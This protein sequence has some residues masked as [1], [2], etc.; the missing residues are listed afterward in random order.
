MNFTENEARAALASLQN[1]LGEKAPEGAVP[2]WVN[3]AGLVAKAMTQQNLVGAKDVT[4]LVEVLFA[5]A[6][7]V[8]ASGMIPP[9][10][11]MVD[12]GAGAGA[13]AL[14]F[15]LAVPNSRAV[16]LEPRRL[17]VEFITETAA[18]LGLAARVEVRKKNLNTDNPQVPGQPFDLALSRA[19]FPPATWVHVGAMI[20]KNVLVFSAAD[21]IP[22]VPDGFAVTKTRSYALPGTGSP[23]TITVYSAAK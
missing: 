4:A 11:T 23:R 2:S 10:T 13:P 15:V 18:Q 17:R 20:A 3:Y 1:A 7:M 22:E 14:P 12:V 6:L 9:G 5:D 19:T 21:P 16:L 8:L